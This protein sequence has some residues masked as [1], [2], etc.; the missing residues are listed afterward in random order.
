M[1]RN[2]SIFFYFLAALPILFTYSH[3]TK[4]NNW[5]LDGVN[6]N[7][8]TE[9]GCKLCHYDQKGGGQLNWDGMNFRDA[10]HDLRYFL[11]KSK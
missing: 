4:T 9:H 8:G 11:A 6:N 2:I 10:G 3:M 1:K 7:C 5:Y